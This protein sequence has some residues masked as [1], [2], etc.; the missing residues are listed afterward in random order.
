LTPKLLTVFLMF[1]CLTGL[2]RAQEHTPGGRFQAVNT[3]GF[4]ERD[5]ERI[6]LKQDFTVGTVELEAQEDT[7]VLLT[8]NG[9]EIRL[10]RLENGLAELKWNAAETAL[11][12]DTDIQALFYTAE[13]NNVPAWGAEIAWPGQGRVQMVLLP[14]GAEAWTGFLISH[15][16]SGTVVRQMEFRKVFGPANR[17]FAGSRNNRGGS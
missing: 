8:I 10:F 3:Q 1:F 16:G 17:P 6:A 5:G 14:L 2:L 7:S 15:P 9:T 11:L 4:F 12:H 13:T